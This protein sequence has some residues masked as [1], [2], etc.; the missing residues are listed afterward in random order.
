MFIASELSSILH[1]RKL[2]IQN[3]DLRIGHVVIDS[4]QI[5]HGSETLFIAIKGLRTDGHKF[6]LEA[7]A[8]GVR[9]FVLNQDFV[10][11]AKLTISSLKDSNVFIVED[12]IKALQDLA[13]YHRTKFNIPRIGITGSNGKTWVKEWLFQLLVANYHIVKSP[14]S[15]NS[16]IGVPLSVLLMNPGHDLA[17]F[18]AGISEVGEM[19]R[20]ENVIHPDIGIL[21][22]L[23]DAHD[24]GFKS[25]E[26]KLK[27]KCALFV[28]SKV[29][30]Y[31]ADDPFITD[32]L[33]GYCP[34]S[35]LISWGRDEGATM[36]IKSISPS[37]RPSDRT[38]VEYEYGDI[39]YVLD[40]PFNDH[41]SI[42][43]ALTCCLVM[44][45][46][47]IPQDEIT[48]RIL[49]LQPV[50]MRLEMHRLDHN[51]LL[52]D[53]SYT[54]DLES[55]QIGLETLGQHGLGR[56]KALIISDIEKQHTDDYHKVAALI[57]AHEIDIVYGIG[58]QIRRIA[59]L[60]GSK[61]RF[62][63]FTTV[64]DFIGQR[65][66]EARSN[67]V[68]LLK[69]ARRFEFEQIVRAMRNRSHNAV[70]EIDLNAMLI[71][72]QFF[73]RKLKPATEIIAMVKASAYGSGSV[74]VG[75]FLQHNNVDRLCVAY[76]DEGV[77]LRKAGVSAPIMVL[78][79]DVN[80]L[81]NLINYRLEP[82]IFD[83]ELL[84]ALTNIPGISDQKLSGSQ[85]GM[86][87][88]IDTGMHRLG[89]DPNEMDTLV[90]ALSAQSNVRVVSVF[91]HLA[92][93]D[94]PDEDEFTRMQIERFTNCCDKIDGALGYT[95]LRHALNTHGILRFPEFQFDAVRL[96]IGLYGVGI[97]YPHELTPVHVLVAKVSQVRRIDK[98]DT[99]GY[100]RS[101]K[102]ERDSV[103]ATINAGYADGI[104]RHAGGG[105]YK[106]YLGG[107][108]APIVG[109][110]CMDMCM[111]DVTD[112]QRVVKGDRIEVFGRH[113][114]IESLADYC[115]T[116][117][118]EILT[119]ISQRIPRMFK[120]D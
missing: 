19:E 33:A 25:R 113:A 100:G 17:I 49:Q 72:L 6:L 11:N 57:E 13:I 88:K 26:E 77:E 101:F 42:E 87:I 91:T 98:G 3:P 27:E 117:S 34:D 99:V 31:P 47:N 55:L 78:N 67:C 38:F 111:I 61:A 108:Y 86:H 82:E 59:N 62:M 35:Q 36:T 24:A 97:C 94:D 95:P 32:R 118:Y 9:N 90:A 106:V 96:G 18:E 41:A 40:I 120:F 114:S 89:F 109:R 44:H 21:T 79:P 1:Q 14:R 112:I 93:S 64:E 48:R 70:L 92:A 74:E 5:V 60:I 65:E 16:Q 110:V 8:M 10:Q 63:L 51:C 81:E 15:Y 115:Q 66:W 119:R 43:N 85:I 30:V 29:V 4:R 37:D 75:K 69:G 46:L 28:N 45:Y 54:L 80:N 76:T 68:F 71:N 12:T 104:P 73:A 84:R 53:D 83:L 52:I 58:D 56:T 23:G 39:D 102:A 116:S 20:L 2:V 7:H 105:G 107:S 22:H 50:K 103:I